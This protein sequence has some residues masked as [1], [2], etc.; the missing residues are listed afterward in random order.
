MSNPVLHEFRYRLKPGGTAPLLV[1]VALG[2]AVCLYFAVV[3]PL[4]PISING[5][6]ISEGKFQLIM[7]RW[8]PSPL[9]SSLLLPRRHSRASRIAA[10]SH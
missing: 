5:I 1:I 4:D 9:F 2:V 10:V 6:E 8:G 3:P 7:V